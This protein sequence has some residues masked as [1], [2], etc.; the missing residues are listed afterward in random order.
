MEV[1][2]D[3]AVSGVAQSRTRLKQLSSSSCWHCRSLCTVSSEDNLC[4]RGRVHLGQVKPCVVT[5]GKSTD[6][7]CCFL[8]CKLEMVIV[9]NSQAFV[10]MFERIIQV[11]PSTQCLI[12]VSY[13]HLLS[14]NM[15]PELFPGTPACEH[16][17]AW[18]PQWPLSCCYKWITIY[19]PT[20]HFHVKPRA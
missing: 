2:V 3:T 7:Q 10:R 19:I 11:K 18:I 17:I 1:T 4:T 20:H 15:H 12:Y 9:P 5:F 13:F 8:T 14:R 6:S 16:F